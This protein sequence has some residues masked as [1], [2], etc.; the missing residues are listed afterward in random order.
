MKLSKFKA[1]LALMTGGWTGLASYLLEVL[2]EALAGAN[3]ETLAKSAE[4]VRGIA[5]V[6]QTAIATFSGQ[7]KPAYVEAG[8]KTVEA[9]NT[10]ALALAD[11]TITADELD[12]NI[13]TVRAAIDAWQA[14]KK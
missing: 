11:G 13:E 4:I 2:N 6:I 8:L 10:L 5:N 12:A 7:M 14:V 3:R 9:V 1:L